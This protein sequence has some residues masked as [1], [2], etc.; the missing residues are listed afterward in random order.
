[1]LGVYEGPAC[2]PGRDRLLGCND[3]FC[4]LQSQLTLEVSSSQEYLIEVGGFDRRVGEG[5]M[6][7][8][9]EGAAPAEF[10]LGDTPDSSNDGSTRMTA[11]T[12]GGTGAVQAHFPTV[13]DDRDG[14][15]RGPLHMQPL[16]VAHLGDAV[17]LEFEADKG[18]DQD[19]V[20]NIEPARDRA[21][22]D[23]AD[24]G[25]ILPVVMPQCDWTSFDYLVNVIEP[26]QDLWVNV[27]CDWNRDGDWDD[28]STT[29]PEMVCGDR[30][31]SEW[32]V[33]NQYLFGLPAGV[34]QISV[35]AFLAWHPEKGPEEIWVRITLSG[36]PWKGGE[37]A[38]TL[39]NG[40]SGPADGYEIG[41]TEDYLISPEVTCPLCED[42]NEDGKV[43]FDDLISLIY[44]WLDC[45][46]Q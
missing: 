25:L 30:P 2:D 26:G 34:H 5:V 19:G 43:D 37:H 31:V 9:C 24:D 15:S 6:T 33:Q 22:Q 3:D 36:Q 42:F 10:D 32:A 28:D 29:D 39:G 20:N 46:S 18:P 35:P 12:G 38:G 17:S 27:W 40:G 11:Y 14:R 21:D 41:E 4:G 13:F 7:I 16:A 23:G 45:C 8:L 1:M 44:K